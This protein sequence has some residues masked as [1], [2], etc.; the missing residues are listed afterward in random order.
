MQAYKDKLHAAL[1]EIAECP[2]SMRTVEQAAAVTDLLC[3]LDKLEDHDE[4]ETV[5]FDRA[6]AMQWAAAMRNADGTTGPHWTMEQ[7]TAVAESIGIQA[8]V[9]PRWAWGVTMNMMYS[10]YYPV[11]VEFGLNRPEFYAALAKA[12]LLDKDGPGPEQ[13][14][15]AYYEHIARS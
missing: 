9:V 12:F 15:M 1:R 13:K 14:L 11:A 5:E 4:P 10:D 7:T 2:V 8:P 3:R 6:T